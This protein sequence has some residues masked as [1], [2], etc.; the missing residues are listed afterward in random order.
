VQQAVA[1]LAEPGSTRRNYQVGDAVFA[2][3]ARS[4]GAFVLILLG[5]L[6]LSLLIGGLPAFRQFGL[7][8]IVS[9][10]WDPVQQVFGAA[11]SI[12]GTLV[13][14]VVSL[15]LAVPLAFGIAFYLTEL[16]PCGASS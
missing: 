13:T 16:A 2:S 6:I 12:Y 8:F 9:T 3:L 11:V 14:S 10:D 4:S 5:S 15:I 7:G 1:T